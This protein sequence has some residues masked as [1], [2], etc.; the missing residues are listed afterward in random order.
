M[1]RWFL[2]SPDAQASAR[3][4][5]LPY[6]GCGASMYRRWPQMAGGLE[7]C[8]VQLPGRENRLRE[9]PPYTFQE[10]AISLAEALLPYLDRPFSFFG[11][12]ASALPGYEVAL[13]LAAR[14][15][16]TPARVFVSSQVAPHQGPH[17]RFLR[18]TEQELRQE[19]RELIV[20]AGGKPLPSLL[21]MSLEVLRADIAMNL[22]YRPAEPV[23]LA[24]P[25]TAIGWRQDA[26]VDPAL[27]AGWADCGE[28][29]FRLLDGEHYRFME[30]PPE[31]LEIFRTD[32]GAR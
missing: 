14:G 26:E 27:M 32:L 8:P 29:V 25:I 19:L 4:F 10:L 3:L 2:R 20:Q 15:Y 24:C 9:D 31:L 21:D 5:C 28:T 13:R 17:G 30:A 23:R 12:C 1:S 11:H 22:R 6:S 16:P 7:I 18:M